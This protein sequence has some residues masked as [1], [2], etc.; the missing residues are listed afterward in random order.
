MLVFA[1]D[2]A[3]T[4]TVSTEETVDGATY[5]AAVL[6]VFVSVP[7]PLPLQLIPETLQD[8]PLLLESLVTL[9]VNFTVWPWSIL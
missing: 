8:T 2:V 4:V 7:Q 5:V 3:F 9:A 6:D 1:T